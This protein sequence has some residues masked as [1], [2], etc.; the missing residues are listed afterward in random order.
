MQPRPHS[1]NTYSALTS[2]IRLPTEALSISRFANHL[3]SV[4]CCAPVPWQET[5][6][7]TWPSPSFTS[8]L[9]LE[10]LSVD[11]RREE[12]EIEAVPVSYLSY[13]R[14]VTGEVLHAD[15]G[16]HAGRS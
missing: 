10:A 4:S 11:W 3:Y 7:C 9:A 12:D 13:A 14:Q 16:A 5:C 8:Q 15:G 1:V 6:C 2:K